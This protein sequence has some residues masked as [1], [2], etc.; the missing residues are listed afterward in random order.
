MTHF[1]SVCSC[2]FVLAFPCLSFGQ[3]FSASFDLQ[4]GLPQAE[5]RETYPQASFGLRGNF[6]YRPDPDIP[7]RIGLELGIQEKG[8]ATEYFTSG[9]YGFYD[10]FKVSAT[11]NIFS[12]MMLT[13]FQP[14]AGFKVKPFLD[15]MAGWNMFFSRVN[16]ERLTYYGPYTLSNKS[17]GKSSW[18]LNYGSAAGVDIPLNSR[19][20]IGLELKVAYLFG[21]YARYLADPYINNNAEVSFSELSS[22]TDMLIP[23]A[24]VRFTIK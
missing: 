16:V 23:Q 4:V 10:E 24:G 13:R 8:R 7:L 18:A 20:D 22:R 14:T 15:L 12:I 9:S 5:Y 11:S 3:K 2:I 1:I 21:N 6:L 19:D 17:A